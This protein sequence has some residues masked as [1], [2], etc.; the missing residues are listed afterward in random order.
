MLP[1][2]R[3]GNKSELGKKVVK[4]YIAGIP[5]GGSQ[6]SKR[7]GVENYEAGKVRDARWTGGT[8]QEYEKKIVGVGKEGWKTRLTTRGNRRFRGKEQE[9][10]KPRQDYRRNWRKRRGASKSKRIKD[11]ERERRR[12]ERGSNRTRT[13]EREGGQINNWGY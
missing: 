6:R 1:Q 11:I 12:V 13:N 4:E 3:S 10:R 2:K 9:K 8:S 7:V 5:R